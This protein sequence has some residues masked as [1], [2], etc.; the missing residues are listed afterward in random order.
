MNHYI[1]ITVILLLFINV[2]GFLYSYLIIK[3]NFYNSFKI[4][5]KNIDLKILLNRI[6][7]VIFNVSILILL[8][9]IGL[10]FFKDIF[11]K[12]FNSYPMLVLEVLAILFVDDFFFYFLHRFMHEN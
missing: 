10:Y 3:K 12:D 7:L 6:P 5:S 2:Y 8:N 11:I 4:Q 1:L 9:I